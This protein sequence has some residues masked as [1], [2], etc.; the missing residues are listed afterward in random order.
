MFV[1]LSLLLGTSDPKAQ[2]PVACACVMSH[3]RHWH[4]RKARAHSHTLP[5]LLLGLPACLS[6]GIWLLPVGEPRP[7]GHECG[8]SNPF[9][10]LTLPAVHHRI[11]ALFRLGLWF[12][13]SRKGVDQLSLVQVGAA[14]LGK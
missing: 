12:K 2:L 11:K 10:G 4:G 3:T 14:L 6:A 13:H 5:T 8:L 1:L 7:H 9:R